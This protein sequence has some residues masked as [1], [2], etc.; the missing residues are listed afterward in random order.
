MKV[1]GPIRGGVCHIRGDVSS[2]FISALLIAAP[3]TRGDTRIE[4]AGSTF[5]K[6]YI[7]LTLQAMA[8][9][10]VCAE[11]KNFGF[12]V[13]GG[14]TYQ[15]KDY[16]V[17]GDY[18]SA[19]FILAA[20][21]I[22][23]SEASVTN[24]RADSLQGDRKIIDILEKMGCSLKVGEDRVSLLAGSSLCG[25]ELDMS[26]TPDLVPITAVLG[27]FAA[28]ETVIKN[29]AHLRFKESDRLRAMSTELAKMGAKIEEGKDFLRIR[30][31]SSLRGGRLCGWNDH[32][33]VMALSVAALRAE[34]RTTIDSAE[35]IDVSFPGYVSA[36]NE[37]GA[38]MRQTEE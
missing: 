12:Q 33:I 25:V 18:S 3:L 23:G 28:G 37:L 7:G 29:V 35:S 17:E 31:D 20:A 13:A 5:S 26:E 11:Q 16:V 30:G 6:P 14:Q 34:G 21:A 32:R 4:V 22:T 9:A 36:M 27:C 19:A 1:S 10:G 8:D 24:L 38:D 2:Q 15:A